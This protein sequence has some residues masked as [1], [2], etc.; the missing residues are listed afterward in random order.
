MPPYEPTTAK[1]SVPRKE[2]AQDV[3][4]R[5]LKSHIAT[6][7]RD[8]GT[9]LTEAEVCKATGTSRTPVREALL[10]LEA[11]GFLEIVPKKGAYVPPISET[12]I[13]V[14]M[15]ARGV[16]EDWCIRRAAS[17]FGA[18]LAEDLERLVERQ[19][20]FRL[21]PVEFIEC[22][23]EFHR[24]IVAAAGNEVFASFYETLRD[25][26]LRM[27]LQ[28]IAAFEQRVGKVLAEHRRIVEELRTSN[29]EGAASAMSEH[30]NETLSALN[31]WGSRPWRRVRAQ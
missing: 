29:A 11:D 20:S 17:R 5:W 7:P 30:L 23:R 4:F 9:F 25:R 10:R 26:Q 27:G 14:T 2:A 15:E 6:L 1:N 22:D 19:E 28:A 13:L 12:E 16:I 24:T 8:H 31:A 3:A 18:A 21:S